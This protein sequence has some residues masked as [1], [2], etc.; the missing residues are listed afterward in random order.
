M[1]YDK[2]ENLGLYFDGKEYFSRIEDVIKEFIKSPF[3][4]GRIDIDGDNM[5][6]N[7]AKYNVEA[8]DEIKYEAHRKYADVQVMIEGEEIIGYSNLSDCTITEDFNGDNDISFMTSDKG[9]MMPLR[10]GFFM[11]L[12]PEDAH[13]PC[14]KSDGAEFAHKLVFKVKI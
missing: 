2:I 13:A 4:S 3:D 11:V 10:K 6:C 1:I 14:L 5:W 9:V 12:F 7:V 8:K